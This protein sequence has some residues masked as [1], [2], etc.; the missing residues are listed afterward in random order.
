MKGKAGVL[1]AS[2]MDLS[3]YLR[4]ERKK[5][6]DRVFSDLQRL[7]CLLFDGYDPYSEGMNIGGFDTPKEQQVQRRTDHRDIETERSGS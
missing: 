2:S 5:P 7:E 6:P 3:D 1:R 4:L